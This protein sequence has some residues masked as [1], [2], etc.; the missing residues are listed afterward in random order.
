MTRDALLVG[1]NCYQQLQPLRAPAKDADALAQRLQ[2][3]GDFRVWRLPEYMNP[4]EDNAR[5]VAQNQ[6]VSLEQLDKALA[7]LF[8][9]EGRTIPDT[10]LFFFS[11]HGL[12]KNWGIREGYL[13]TSDVDPEHGNW[14]LSL[15]SLQRLLCESPIQQPIVWLDCC[16]SGELLNFTEADPGKRAERNSLFLIASSREYE[17]SIEAPDHGLLTAALL[18]GLDFKQ[19]PTGVVT[20]DTLIEVIEHELKGAPQQPLWVNPNREI[21]LTGKP[22]QDLPPNLTGICPYNGLRYFDIQDASYFYGREKLTDQLLDHV[23]LGKGNFL[24]VLGASGSGKSSVVRAGL[25]Y[26]LQQGYRISGSEQWD[27]QIMTPGA[28]PVGNLAETFLDQNTTNIDR[29]EQL[30]KAT[31]AISEGADGLARLI[32]VSRSPRTILV[33]DQFEEVFTLCQNPAE[34]HH[35]FACLINALGL[36]EDKLCIVVVMRADFLGKC[37]EQ[38]YRG[39]ANIM[40]SNLVTVKPMA[41][42]E[43]ERAICEPATK[44]G[45]RVDE[46]LVTQILMD[47][48]VDE[49]SI[50]SETDGIEPTWEAGSLPL[51]EYTLEQL[52]QYRTLD[53]LTLDSYIRLGGVKQALEN[54]ADSVY[55]AF[56]VEEQQ[57]AK[58]IFLALTQLGEGTEDTRRLVS[59]E[60]LINPQQSQEQLEQVIQTLAAER[61]IVTNEVLTK[62]IDSQ[63]QVILDIAHEALIRHW[64]RLRL[65]ISGH[66][67]AIRVARKIESV[68]QEW[69]GYDKSLE[70]A[71]LLQG[72]KLTE[73][74][75]FLQDYSE[76]GLLS[77]LSQELIQ[78]SQEERDRLQQEEQERQQ[79]ELTQERKVVRNKIVA[80]CV[81]ALAMISAISFGWWNDQQLQKGILDAWSDV[82]SDRLNLFDAAEKQADEYRKSGKISAALAY[83]RRIRESTIESLAEQLNNSKYL[84]T[85]ID[86][87]KQS[88][89][90]KLQKTLQKKDEFNVAFRKFEKADTTLIQLIQEHKF[91]ALSIDIKNNKYGYLRLNAKFSDL[92]KRFTQ[93]ALRKTYKILFQPYGIG[94]D[95]NKNGRLDSELEATQ[96]PCKILL[97]IERLWQTKGC[98]WYGNNPYLPI[99]SHC[100]ALRNNTLANLMFKD[101]EYYHLAIARLKGCKEVKQAR[102][103]ITPF[104]LKIFDTKILYRA[105]ANW[106]SLKQIKSWRNRTCL[107]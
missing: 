4:F 43:L 67:D 78:V 33:I 51:L 72:Q 59:K 2:N 19:Q 1:I 8:K 101:R 75:G 63:R 105:S 107:L 73:A 100:H 9:P 86:S 61:L 58:H 90:K 40:Q 104:S 28:H 13:A 81:T 88:L 102:K 30:Q 47:L 16:Y 74:E 45:L 38:E 49:P 42:V 14:G 57:V 62:G 25:V 56:S 87:G 53:R 41:K 54:R 69:K 106:Q 68:A 39:L 70:V 77:S 76:L 93:G 92:E 23:K 71:Y 84:W 35:F 52:W 27:I 31:T 50:S 65:W 37:T 34:K 24:A 26:Q 46:N 97:E 79:R 11:G 94:A 7:Q 15:Q 89:P 80:I 64:K 48:N 29:A 91:K 20:N 21:L 99:D 32:K 82:D 60:D 5:R 18:K 66:R 22:E 96:M 10:A 6:D 103:L 3:D 55:Q 83:Y 36:T 95:L 98:K 17:L 85:L 44:I 12:R